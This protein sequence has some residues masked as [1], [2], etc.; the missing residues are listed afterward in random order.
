MNPEIRNKIIVQAIRKWSTYAFATLLFV[1][2][3]SIWMRPSAP[4]VGQVLNNAF[5]LAPVA[6]ASLLMLPFL[7]REMLADKNRVIG[8]IRRLRG[9]LQKLR[10]GQAL[11]TLRLRDGDHWSGQTPDDSTPTIFSIKRAGG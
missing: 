3:G 1:S 6:F 11:R 8:P 4:A 5:S 9:E 10:E 7:I 2:L